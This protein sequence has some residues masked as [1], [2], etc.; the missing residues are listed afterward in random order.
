[1]ENPKR[2]PDL[3]GIEIVRLNKKEWAEF[4]QGLRAQLEAERDAATSPEE[5]LR[6]AFA[7]YGQEITSVDF[8]DEDFGFCDSQADWPE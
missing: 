8:G 5:N 1:M 3:S 4:E 7:F 2:T 6:Q